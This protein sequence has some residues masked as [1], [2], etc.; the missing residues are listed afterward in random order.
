[1][2]L[3]IESKGTRNASIS[4]WTQR[5]LLDRPRRDTWMYCGY[6]GDA[7][8]LFRRVSKDAMQC[9]LTSNTRNG[10]LMDITF[11]CS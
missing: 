11:R 10:A 1:M 2:V 3:L 7:I 8:Q 6:G 4:Q 9:T 5:W